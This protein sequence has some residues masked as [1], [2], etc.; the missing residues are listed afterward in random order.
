M[1]LL[2][3]IIILELVARCNENKITV[4]DGK[5]ITCRTTGKVKLTV[6]KMRLE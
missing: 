5:E 4:V 1:V 2:Y 3:F 6:H